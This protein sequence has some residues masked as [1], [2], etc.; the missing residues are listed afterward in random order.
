MPPQAPQ[1]GRQPKQ[2]KTRSKTKRTQTAL[3]L[4]A[5]RTAPQPLT[6]EDL[7]QR[8]GVD[9]SRLKRNVTRLVAQGK[10]QEMSAGT[11]CGVR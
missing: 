4:A 9:G 6:I 5:I 10:I 1:R 7:R 8:P 3:I 11:F 2:G